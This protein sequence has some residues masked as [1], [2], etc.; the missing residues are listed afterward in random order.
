MRRHDL[1]PALVEL[2]LNVLVQFA[3]NPGNIL[4]GIGV[5]VE[6]IADVKIIE[7]RLQHKRR[8]RRQDISGGPGRGNEQ[9]MDR[10]PG[11]VVADGDGGMQNQTIAVSHLL[12]E[13]ID[14]AVEDGVVGDGDDLIFP[15]F[16]PGEHSVGV[17]AP[18]RWPLQP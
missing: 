5:G 9:G 10:F 8:R 3:V 7:R 1:H 15:G 11:G 16:Y 6:L 17:P 12:T 2:I 14:V 4:R 18:R 13:V